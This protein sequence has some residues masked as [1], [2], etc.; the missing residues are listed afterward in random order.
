MELW[1]GLAHRPG[2]QM[3]KCP[4]LGLGF[5]TQHE[6]ATEQ[7]P[8]T[9]AMFCR[10]TFQQTSSQCLQQLALSDAQTFPEMFPDNCV[11]VV[12]C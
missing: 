5:V 4:K 10:Q 1:W 8:A 2:L 6:S 11:Y 12:Y 7:P 3:S 9:L